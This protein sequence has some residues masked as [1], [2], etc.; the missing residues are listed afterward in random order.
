[1][2]ALCVREENLM[3]PARWCAQMREY[4]RQSS[5]ESLT[6]E[7]AERLMQW[8]TRLA[9]GAS[10]ESDLTVQSDAAIP[11][12]AAF[13]AYEAAVRRLWE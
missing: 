8:G 3:N 1:M 5:N 9:I 2:L 13:N 11:E 4:M 7:D 10:R 6:A 12:V